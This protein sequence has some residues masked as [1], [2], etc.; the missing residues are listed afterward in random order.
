MSEQTY[1][2]RIYTLVATGE[3]DDALD[4]LI[5]H[6]DDLFLAG[7]W[8]RCDEDL[9]LID[10]DRLD[11]TLLVGVLAATLCAKAHLPYRATLLPLIRDRLEE[12]DPSRV[13][14]LLVGLA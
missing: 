11:I 14:R 13:E 4:V 9:R 6:F 10:L 2:E 8:S 7:G 5:D 1:I 3:V 12:R